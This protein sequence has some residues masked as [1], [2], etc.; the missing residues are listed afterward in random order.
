MLRIAGS[1]PTSP[2]KRAEVKKNK[3]APV[4]GGLSAFQPLQQRPYS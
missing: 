1:N 4:A 3:K 2:R